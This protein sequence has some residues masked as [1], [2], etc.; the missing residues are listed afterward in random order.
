MKV[1]LE[2]VDQ[3]TFLEVI[4]T[5]EELKKIEKKKIASQKVEI[6]DEVVNVGVRLIQPGE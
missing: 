2:T 3:E 5:Q 6:D 1:I 4:L